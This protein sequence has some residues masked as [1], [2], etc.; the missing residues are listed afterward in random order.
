MKHP[1]TGSKETYMNPP[2]LVMNNFTT[3]TPTSTGSENGSRKDSVPKN[4]ESLITTVFQ[5]LFPPIS[6]QTTPL[7][8]IR[9]ILLLD[10]MS[11]AQ[12]PS[13]GTPSDESTQEGTYTLYLR[14]YHISTKVTGLP[15]S[16][17]RLQ[18][19]ERAMTG[20]RSKNGR[21]PNLG[22][23]EDVADYFLGEAAGYTSA[24][25]TEV[26]TDAEVEVIQ[27]PARKVLGKRERDEQRA[28][29]ATGEEAPSHTREKGRVEKR[30]V[31]MTELGPR[32]KL[33]LTKVE[34]GLCGGKV[35]WHEF[36]TKSKEEVK[37]M[38]ALWEKRNAERAERRRVQKENVERKKAEKASKGGK[39]GAEDDDEDED[40]VDNM[41]LDDD[42]WDDDEYDGEDGE[43]GVEI[44]QEGEDD[45][46]EEEDE[47]G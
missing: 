4:L 32:M 42:E 13:N 37:Q 34:D 31:K 22:K 17:K 28:R 30:A 18:R 21:I 14:H 35:L 3:Q 16:I 26:E 11:K 47:E 41:D 6:P 27:Q 19:A 7:N 39:P 44:E 38:D 20:D 12:R 10:R 8:S 9:R 23:M 24:S 29:A 36:I 5:S 1:K 46:M 40:A 15:K 33:R 45:D 43:N 2:L 25:D